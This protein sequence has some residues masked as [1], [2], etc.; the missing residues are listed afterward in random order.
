MVFPRRFLFM[1]L[2]FWLYVTL[3][4][5]VKQSRRCLPVGVLML[6]STQKHQFGKNIGGGK[7]IGKP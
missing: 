1:V 6:D 5:L 3:N 2:L 4:K 7:E